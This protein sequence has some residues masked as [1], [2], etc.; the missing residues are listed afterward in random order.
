MQ[1]PEL[2]VERLVGFLGTDPSI[3]RVRPLGHESNEWFARCD[4]IPRLRCVPIADAHPIRANAPPS[5]GFRLRANG[6]SSVALV[7]FAKA[8]ISARWKPAKRL[9]SV[10]ERQDLFPTVPAVAMDLESPRSAL[11]LGAPPPG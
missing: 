4:C 6:R 7:H 5:E 11:P 1:Y 3:S 2:V 9:S 10:L 8:A